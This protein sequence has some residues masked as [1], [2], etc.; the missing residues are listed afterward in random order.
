MKNEFSES[1]HCNREEPT[2]S[3][4]FKKIKNY[5]ANECRICSV[6]LNDENK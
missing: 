4:Q 3:K 5:P 2:T 1:T 6:C